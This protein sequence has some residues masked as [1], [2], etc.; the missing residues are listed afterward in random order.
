MILGELQNLNAFLANS[1]TAILDEVEDQSKSLGSVLDFLR[2]KD[3]KEEKDKKSTTTKASTGAAKG[4]AGKDILSGFSLKDIADNIGKLSKG[5]IVFAIASA[6]GSPKKFTDFMKDLFMAITD[7]GKNANADKIAKLW[8]AVGTSLSLIGHSVGS[9]G[10]GLIMFGIAAKTGATNLFITFVQKFFSSN[11]MG[12]LKP[13]PAEQVG[14]ALSALASGILKF[15]G[16]VALAAVLL[17]VAIPALII[18]IPVVMLT[19]AAMGMISKQKKTI[20]TGAKSIEHMAMGLLVFTGAL[21]L[22]R[23]VRAED[24]LMAAGVVAVFSLFV[25]A[26]NL[27]GRISGGAKGAEQSAKSMMTMGLGLIAITGAIMLMR[28]VQVADILKMALTIAVLGLFMFVLG[29]SKDVKSGAVAM[30]IIAISIGIL[31]FTINMFAKI[32]WETIGKVG[33]CIGGLTLALM[34]LGAN[35]KDVLIGSLSLII[36]S[37]S[38]GILAYTMSYWQKAKID[39]STMIQVGLAIGGL[40][41]ALIALGIAGP[42][43]LLGAAALA[44]VALSFA[45]S[46]KLVIESLDLFK[47]SKWQEADNKLLNST[48]VTLPMSIMEGFL[49]GGGPLILLALPALIA[50]GLALAPIAFALSTF[51]KEG[52]TEADAISA[53]NIVK[54]M[55]VA[56]RAPIEELGKGSG[57]FFNG[58]FENGLDAARGLGHF[59]AELAQGIVAMSKMQFKGLD[60]KIVHLTDGDITAVGN[61]VSK[62]LTAVKDPIAAIGATNVGVLGK[63]A[64]I[65]AGKMSFNDPDFKAGLEAVQ[66]L[67]HFM[68]ELAEGTMAMAKNQYKGLDGKIVT[69]G[70]GEYAQVGKNVGAIINAVKQPIIDAGKVSDKFTIDEGNPIS[71]FFGKAGNFVNQMFSDPDFKKGL[72]AVGGLGGFLAGL[73]DGAMKLASGKFPDINDPKNTVTIASALPQIGKNVTDII[74]AMRG[75]I[76]DIGKQEG[77]IFAGPFSKGMESVSKL[78]T[79]IGSI[80]DA[81]SKLA[82]GKFPDPEFP[83]DPANGIPAKF[84]TLD[85]KAT[86]GSIRLRLLG[87][88]QAML[89]PIKDMIVIANAPEVEK[90]QTGITALTGLYKGFADI[91]TSAGTIL[92]NKTLTDKSFG[93]SLSAAFT[94]VNSAARSLFSDSTFADDNSILR[95]DKLVKSIVTLSGVDTKL[96]GVAASM[97]EIST[98]MIS[99]FTTLNTVATEKLDALAKLFNQLVELDKIDAEALDRKIKHYE[100]LIDKAKNA[101]ADMVANGTLKAAEKLESMD[102]KMDMLSDSFQEMIGLLQQIVANTGG[103]KKA[104]SFLNQK[105]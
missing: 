80:A 3:K 8:E 76:E 52:V 30:L 102:L 103:T 53:G 72:D 41:V 93:P 46:F 57:I 58:D 6:T 5:L 78:G 29:E 14:L 7:S 45:Y 97:K 50:S 54:S 10:T 68:K 21:L 88:V 47:K 79:F 23:F 74:N 44:I 12:K 91:V 95:F 34:L 63:F 66:G 98:S 71:A 70:G 18:L 65:M 32:E 83:G 104:I 94:A 81:A 40:T 48:L 19:M 20:D 84:I 92:S 105:P 67:G 13:K 22:M 90:A 56:V 15:V 62:I 82:V 69:L 11:V 73:A 61:N 36:A 24:L 86:M 64:G 42:M 1:V 2:D 49:K 28:F 31:A 99:T 77:I 89:D 9:L 25:L 16:Y 43:V 60:G 33:A 51:K 37:V 100:E 26:I 4:A 38:V 39:N 85:D 17:P 75:P 96:K 27:V 35:G 87:L 101:N 55:L 59:M